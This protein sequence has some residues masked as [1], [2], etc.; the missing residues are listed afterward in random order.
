M[1]SGAWPLLSR[2]QALLYDFLIYP[3]LFFVR[4][5]AAAALKNSADAVRNYDLFLQYSGDRPDRFGRLA[6]AK[7]AS[8]L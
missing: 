5:E 6:R 7:A 3:N 4:A 2:E 8:R 1:L